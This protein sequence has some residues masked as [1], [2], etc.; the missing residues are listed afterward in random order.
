MADWKHNT[1]TTETPTVKM[2]LGVCTT[3][4]LG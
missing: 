4:E 1:F 2:A 3:E